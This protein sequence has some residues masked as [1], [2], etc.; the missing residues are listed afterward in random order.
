MSN[1]R[2]WLGAAAGVLALL[3][4][5]Q[6]KALMIAP[7]PLA[8]RIA[9][10][11]V[12]VVGKVS[13][14]GPKLVKADVYKGDTR[15]MQIAI[16]KV[17]STLFGKE[18]KEIKVGFFPPVTAPPVKDVFVRPARTGPQLKQDEESCLILVEHPTQKGVYLMQGY[19]DVIPKANN[20]NFAKDVETIKKSA[21]L[22][23]KPMDGL[24]SK[25]AGERLTTAAL[26]VARYRARPLGEVKE[27]QASAQ[28][29]KAVL[30]AL[31]D[32]EW[33]TAK[34]PVR[35][36][37]INAQNVFFQLGLTE[38]DGWKFPQDR[39]KLAEE[40]K[41]WCKDN[42]GKY[43]ITRFVRAEAAEKK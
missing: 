7:A 40:A 29:S 14:F 41:K 20:N 9:P 30:E 15:D 31:A 1:K 12:V 35:F 22:L 8:T 10:A 21:K 38:K 5:T 28:E 17:S 33:P 32:A 6:A 26:V 18:E 23:Q 19:F 39:T 11:D 36:D 37:Q 4:V 2:I 34:T 42:A 16:V 43:R 13:G 3:T 24:K 27:E 25:D